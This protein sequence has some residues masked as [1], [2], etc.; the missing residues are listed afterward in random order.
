MAMDLSKGKSANMLKDIASKSSEENGK[1]T[2]RNI[3]IALIDKSDD[4]EKI[5]NMG[6]RERLT[7][8][9]ERNGFQGTVQVYLNKSGRYTLLSGHR[10]FE[11]AKELGF[12]DIPCEIIEEP[13]ETQKAEILIMSNVVARDLTPVEKGRAIKYYEVHVLDKEGFKGDKRAELGKRFGIAS[14]QVYKLK[15]LA[16]I[17]RPLQN[18]VEQGDITYASIYL[19]ANMDEETQMSIYKDIIRQIDAYGSILGK[20]VEYIVKLRTQPARTES[21]EVQI[22]Q[23]ESENSENGTLEERANVE[24]IITSEANTPLF[25]NRKA[26]ETNEFS[27]P[28]LKQTPIP[29]DE[30]RISSNARNLRTLL[31]GTREIKSEDVLTELKQLKEVLNSINL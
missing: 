18:L 20:D 26:F 8:A 12:K 15:A 25:S 24:N 3:D 13:S 16:D 28:R 5:F 21:K 11:S 23:D 10:R 30:L 31:S 22:E 29:Y 14:S 17:I 6:N 7:N 2:T 19:C 9:I 1:K 27:S 4:N